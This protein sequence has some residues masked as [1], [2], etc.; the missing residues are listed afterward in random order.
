MIVWGVTWAQIVCII[1]FQITRVQSRRIVQFYSTFAFQ[2]QGFIFLIEDR[3]WLNPYC[4]NSLWVSEVAEVLWN[5]RYMMKAFWR[6]G[7]EGIKTRA[8]FSRGRKKCPLD[9]ME[10]T[11]TE[12]LQYWA[13]NVCGISHNQ[14]TSNYFFCRER[15]SLQSIESNRNNRKVLL[16]CKDNLVWV[17]SKVSDLS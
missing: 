1:L 3:C 17:S 13:T 15:Q 9:L 16:M 12:V 10:Q 2:L 6:E 4:N 5:T 14:H 8:S 7:T 11:R